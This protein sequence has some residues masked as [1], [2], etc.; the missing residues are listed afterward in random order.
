[1]EEINRLI[2][3]TD[4]I[5]ST[6]IIPIFILTIIHLIK[7]GKEIS[8]PAGIDFISLLICFNFG[9]LSYP[10]PFRNILF[11]D[12]RNYFKL[13]YITLIFTESL[14][15]FF[16]IRVETKIQ[17]IYNYKLK[18]SF[19]D[20]NNIDENDLIIPLSMENYDIRLFV[21]H[22]LAWFLV[23]GFFLINISVLVL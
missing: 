12:L 22:S 1:M 5:L 8:Q 19:V 20:D 16:W 4:V 14:T 2:E 13:F 17:R 11:D 3:N 9:V 23:F 10:E 21:K 7:K 15:L 6:I 18:R